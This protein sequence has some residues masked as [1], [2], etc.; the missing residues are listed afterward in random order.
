MYAT[1][2]EFDSE[3][4]YEYPSIVQE[5]KN[6]ASAHGFKGEY[7]V[8]GP[9]WWT[10]PEAEAREW[11]I[12]YSDI[13]AAKYHARGIVMHLGMDVGV[14]IQGPSGYSSRSKIDSTIR[15]LCTLMEGARPITLPMEI[16]STATNLKSYS[17]SLPDSSY[18]I[19]VWTDGIAVDDDPG[20]TT[21]LVLHGFSDQWVTGIDVLYGFQQQMIT[22]TEDEDLVIRNLM[23]KDYPIILHL[24]P[25]RYIFLPLVLKGYAH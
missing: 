18:L 14:G 2:P 6:V 3:Y 13:V 20:I 17:F 7:E 21:T 23:V 15:N 24:V 9:C 10:E 19:A 25:T 5:I 22:D 12:W 16:Q 1:S 11:G 8:E 4:Y